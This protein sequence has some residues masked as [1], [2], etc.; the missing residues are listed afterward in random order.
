MGYPS[1]VFFAG[2][3]CSGISFLGIGGQ[4]LFLSGHMGGGIVLRLTVI[5]VEGSLSNSF[6]A[7]CRLGRGRKNF[8]T[9][10]H[11]DVLCLK[12]IKFPFSKKNLHVLCAPRLQLV[13]QMPQKALMHA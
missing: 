9:M 8:K 5:S 2:Q 3:A 7:V 10:Y 1:E 13:L 12:S 11:L 4:G 6:Y